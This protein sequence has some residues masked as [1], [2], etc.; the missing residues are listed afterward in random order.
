MFIPAA[1]I[2]YTPIATDIDECLNNNGGCSQSCINTTGSYYCTCRIG[3]VL[4]PN[5]H[6]CKSKS[7]AKHLQCKKMRSQ[8]K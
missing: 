4:Q 6:D 2:N 3:Y 7:Y 8:L 1:L 5:G